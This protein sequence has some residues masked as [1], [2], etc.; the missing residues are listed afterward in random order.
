VDIVAFAGPNPH[1]KPYEGVN[2]D[3]RKKN[4]MERLQTS[5]ERFVDWEQRAMAW[6]VDQ[7]NPSRAKQ[8]AFWRTLMANRT[9]EMSRP[10][11][12]ELG[13][14]AWWDNIFR[15][16]ATCATQFPRIS[17]AE[18]ALPA[19]KPF[20]VA[21]VRRTAGRCFI[22]TEKGYFGI[23]PLNT[24]PGDEVCVIEGGRV[25]FVL[26]QLSALDQE[27]VI[28]MMRRREKQFVYNLVGESYF[29]G[30]S[31]G[32]WITARTEEDVIEAILV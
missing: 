14:E 3:E 20:T 15:A 30:V 12:R 9:S 1:I 18:E 8:R 23:G 26:R 24:Q 2:A 25:P 17:D 27:M 10:S 21:A 29:Y 5:L 7:Y 6:P 28:S 32:E 16:A 31:D 19:I 22:I 11:L 4:Q 13:D